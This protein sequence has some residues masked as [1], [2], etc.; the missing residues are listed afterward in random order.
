[1]ALD[2]ELSPG[3]VAP[4]AAEGLDEEL[5]DGLEG[6]LGEAV[7]PV[8][9]LSLGLLMPPL[10]GDV[11]APEEELPVP[12]APDAPEELSLDGLP[13]LLAPGLAPPPAP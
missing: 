3:A 6:E 10:L 1:L 7:L 4:P 13:L 5:D 8:D 12:L 9:E 2:D 11:V